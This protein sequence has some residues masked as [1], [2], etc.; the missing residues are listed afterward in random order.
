MRD[1]DLIERARAEIAQNGLVKPSIVQ[2]LI[3]ALERRAPSVPD[4]INGHVIAPSDVPAAVQDA[5][6]EIAN[7]WMVG[8]N[9]AL[10]WVEGQLTAAPEARSEAEGDYDPDL[11]KHCHV[12]VAAQGGTRLALLRGWPVHWDEAL[13][14]QVFSDTGE[15]TEKTWALRPCGVCGLQGNSNYGDPDP[16]LGQLPGVTSACCGHGDRER[17]HVRFQGGV[18]LRGFVVDQQAQPTKSETR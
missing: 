10:R 7:A 3:A 6:S 13:G 11:V 12:N 16:C 8:F 9:S 18:V 4:W 1:T 17:A 2:D 5:G 15:P 14:E